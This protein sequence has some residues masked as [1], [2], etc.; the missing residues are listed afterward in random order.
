M[1]FLRI[2]YLNFS[3]A[4]SKAIFLYRD[5]S[6]PPIRALLVTPSSRCG[7][8]HQGFHPSR[9]VPSPWLLG[10]QAFLCLFLCMVLKHLIRFSISKDQNEFPA[11]FGKS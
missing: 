10:T 6:R 1:H 8:L 3:T 11:E 7:V 5:A 4:Y 2:S 9:S